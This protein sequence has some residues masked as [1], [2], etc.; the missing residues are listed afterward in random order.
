[1]SPRKGACPRSDGLFAR[2][3]LVP[4]PSGLSPAQ[5]EAAAEDIG[6]AVRG[7]GSL[8]TAGQPS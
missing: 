3:L 5:D 1:V 4:I 7:A 2:S 8:L 6:S